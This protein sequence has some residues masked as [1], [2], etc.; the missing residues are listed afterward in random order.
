MHVLRAIA[1]GRR[2]PVHLLVVGRGLR[3]PGTGPVVDEDEAP[4]PLSPYGRTKLAGEQLVRA[5]ARSSS[6][7]AV[8]LRYFNVAGA[9][10]PE[11]GDTGELNL[12]TQALARLTR[13]RAPRGLRHRLADAATAAASG[14]TCTC[15]T[16]PGRTRRALDALDG[17]GPPADRV[18]RRDRPGLDRARDPGAARRGDRA[19]RHGRASRR[20][21]PGDAASVV[22]A[23]DNIRRR[24]RVG[25]RARYA[26]LLSRARGRPGRPASRRGASRPQ[27]RPRRPRTPASRTARRRGRRRARA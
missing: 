16:W 17:R 10:W 26:T 24:P 27:P 9:G 4:R 14:T 19:G 11:L 2:R 23:V 25:G 7:R 21:G 20:G 22:A 8:S 5:V 3:L 12:V 6:L 15:S 18:Q 1:R 13:G